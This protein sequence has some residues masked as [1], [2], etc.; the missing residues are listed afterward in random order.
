VSDPPLV[1]PLAEIVEASGIEHPNG[2]PYEHI[3]MAL[4]AWNEEARLGKL[5]DWLRPFFRTLAVAVQESDDATFMIAK[6]FADVLVLDRHH[7]FGDATFGPKLLPQIR[8]P[9]TFKVDADE[10]P[11]E[12][13]LRSLS[14]ATWYAEH[15]NLS[16]LWIPFRSWVDGREY[17]EQHSHLR[18][19]RTEAGWPRTL[20]SRPLI[21]NTAVWQTGFIEHRRTLDEMMQDYLRYWDAGLGNRGWED[22]NRLMM[23]HACRGT[24][25]VR[26]WD[27]VRAFSWWPRVEAIAFTEEQPWL[28][29]Q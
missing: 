7:G 4:V 12:T 2:V 9:W 29:S 16:G 26:G 17:E 1:A 21:D 8:T 24:A 20:H 22:H 13:L 14:S 25:E 3:T 5:L 19:F 28:S 10:V 23:F 27:Y 6:E 18:L 15:H 11:D